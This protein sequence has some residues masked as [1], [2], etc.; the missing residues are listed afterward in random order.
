LC[1]SCALRE[2]RELHLFWKTPHSHDGLLVASDFH[3][4]RSRASSALP[5]LV[6]VV[7]AYRGQKGRAGE[8]T[9]AAGFEWHAGYANASPREQNCHVERWHRRWFPPLVYYCT[10]TNLFPAVACVLANWDNVLRAISLASSKLERML[11]RGEVKSLT[12]SQKKLADCRIPL[13]PRWR[14]LRAS[15]AY[16]PLWFAS[17]LNRARRPANEAEAVHFSISVPL[18]VTG[19]LLILPTIGPTP[20]DKPPPSAT[21]SNCPSP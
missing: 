17:P 16:Q 7:N 13:G 11:I 19:G 18:A 3:A 1:L 10:P 21:S 15:L 2:L 5:A 12:L 14:H 8:S 20:C 6:G 4:S 9:P